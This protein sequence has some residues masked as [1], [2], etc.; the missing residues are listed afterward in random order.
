MSEVLIVPL[1]MCPGGDQPT[2]PWISGGAGNLKSDW[3]DSRLHPDC[4]AQRAFWVVRQVSE[5]FAIVPMRL[6]HSRQ[7]RYTGRFDRCRTYDRFN[8]TGCR[9]PREVRDAVLRGVCG[10]D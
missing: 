8:R 1:P 2:L 6:P 9:V 4:R 5:G 10:T 7:N 3:P